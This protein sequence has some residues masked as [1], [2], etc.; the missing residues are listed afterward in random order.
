MKDNQESRVG[1]EVWDDEVFERMRCRIGVDN[2]YAKLG[3]WDKWARGKSRCMEMRGDMMGAN[4]RKGRR[5]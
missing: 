1:S 5:T 4:K 2:R 3:K